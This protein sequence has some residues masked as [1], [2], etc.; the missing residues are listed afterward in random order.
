MHQLSFYLFFKKLMSVSY[1][2]YVYRDIFHMDDSWQHWNSLKLNFKYPFYA[3][4]SLITAKYFAKIYEYIA[5]FPTCKITKTRN[6][7]NILNF[8]WNNIYLLSR[9]V[10]SILKYTCF[11]F[12][13]EADFRRKVKNWLTSLHFIFL[14]LNNVWN[15]VL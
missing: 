10:V 14:L 8:K 15:N 2:C 3:T 1:Y 11:F 7:F 6:S 13:A 9:F 5:I 12:S 4:K